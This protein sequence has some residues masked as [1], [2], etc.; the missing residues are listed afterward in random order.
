MSDTQSHSTSPAF[1]GAPVVA[2]RGATDIPF[3]RWARA[4]L[5][6][7]WVNSAVTLIFTYFIV[8]LIV[9]VLSWGVFNAVW[10][11]PG[12]IRRPAARLLA[13]AHAGR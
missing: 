7:T 8:K 6:N 3:I 11:V 4:N 9:A 10:E 5:F 13:S 1:A 2:R 12:R